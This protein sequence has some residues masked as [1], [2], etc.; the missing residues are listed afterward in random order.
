VASVPWGVSSDTVACECA[1]PTSHSLDMR[2]LCDRVAVYAAILRFFEII[3]EP[4]SE[5]CGVGLVSFGIDR[6]CDVISLHSAFHPVC[7]FL[8]INSDPSRAP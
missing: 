2:R 8:P 4:L 3:G 7:H 5:F 6:V 1:L